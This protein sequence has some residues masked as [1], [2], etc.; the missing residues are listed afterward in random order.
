MAE[1][2][3]AMH[4]LL[5]HVGERHWRAVGIV[6][7]FQSQLA[8]QLIAVLDEECLALV[9]RIEKLSRRLNII[10]RSG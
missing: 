3:Q 6:S 7:R 10:A 5:A 4:A 9:Q 1:R 2:D 8:S